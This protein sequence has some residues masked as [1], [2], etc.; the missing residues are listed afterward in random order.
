MRGPFTLTIDQSLFEE[1]YQHLFPGDGDEHGAVIAAGLS[2]TPQ[3]TRLLARELFL[4][5]DGEDYVPGKRGY[6][7]LTAQFVA[8]VS[9]YCASEKLCYLAI[10]CHRGNDSVDF[11]SDDMASHER[12]YPAL[13][14]I[15]HGG[16][17]GALVFAK[18]AIAGDIWTRNGRFALT[19]T[20]VVGNHVYKIYPQPKQKPK[21]AD[22]IYDR[23]TRLF[24]DIGQ[25]ILSGLKIGIIGLGGGGSLLNEWMAR[26]G[27]GRIIAVDFDKI[28]P[29]NLP[30]VVGSTKW[31][32]KTIL[33]NSKIPIFQKIGQRYSKH[34]V[35]IAKRVAKE[36]NQKIKF[37]AIVGSILDENTAKLLKDTDFI[38]LATDNIQSRLVFNA[39]I[40][41]YIIPGVQIGIKIPKDT[42][43]QKI[44]DITANTRPVFPHTAGGCLECYDLILASKLQEE[45]ISEEQLKVQRYVDDETISEPSVITLNVLSAAQAAN[46]LMMIFTGLYEKRVKL[47][48]QI[49]FAR[50]RELNSVEMHSNLKCPDCS[51]ESFSRRGRGDRVRLPCRLN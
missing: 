28:D 45:S 13:L 29:T 19:Y 41:Q 50:N 7:A 10:H 14:D 44:G 30:R 49:N 36:S 25:E 46:D 42:K 27:V 20:K 47:E 11:S 15:T 21:F 24:G 31:D 2:E 18:N 35:D 3:G 51:N 4:A 38:F 22:A 40:Q 26:L 33:R 9:D 48:H 12:G 6:R 23:N 1:L 17:V 39:L 37:D 32:A 8:E 5:K 34:K 16:P 43:T